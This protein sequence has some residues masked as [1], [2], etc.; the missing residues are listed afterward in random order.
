MASEAR[1]RSRQRLAPLFA[2]LSCRDF[3][4]IATLSNG[5][6]ARRLEK[7]LARLPEGFFGK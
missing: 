5:D 6:L 1:E 3:S 4:N 2:W 7:G